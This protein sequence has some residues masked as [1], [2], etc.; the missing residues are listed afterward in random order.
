MQYMVTGLDGKEYGPSD[1]ETLKTWVAENRLAPHTILRDFGTGGTMPASEVPG[2]F[3]QTAPVSVPP[4]GAAYPRTGTTYTAASDASRDHGGG[5]LVGVIL[6]SVGAIVMFY[7]LG[8]YGF[9]F[10]GYAMYYAIQCLQSG[11]KY[12]IPAVVI[13]GIALAAVG[14]GWALRLS[15]HPA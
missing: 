10:A 11:S 9:F 4:P 6:R 12:G 14:V 2:L 1:L 13:A 15:G 3:A 8:G 7:F 5:V